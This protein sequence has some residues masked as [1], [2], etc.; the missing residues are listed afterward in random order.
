MGGLCDRPAMECDEWSPR[1]RQQL[2]P[3]STD[4][5]H[6]FPNVRVHA[7]VAIAE[8]KTAFLTS[9]NLTGHALEKKVEAGTFISGRRVLA[10]L[11]SHLRAL[12][13]T[14]VIQPAKAAVV[15][16][17]MG[18]AARADGSS[19]GVNHSKWSQRIGARLRGFAGFFRPLWLTVGPQTL[20]NGAILPR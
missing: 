1:D 8:G 12:I 5:P 14:K 2:K 17:R 20:R 16:S 3:P 6:T 7:K 18:G 10:N 19:Q 15:E 9:A 11:Q 13:K 4:R